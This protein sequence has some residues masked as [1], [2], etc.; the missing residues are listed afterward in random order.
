MTAYHT[1]SPFTCWVK[2]APL[3]TGFRHGGEG[4][5]V[6]EWCGIT[7]VP[8]K[9]QLGNTVGGPY[10]DMVIGFL[11]MCH[12]PS[13]VLPPSHYK[14]SLTP[15][16]KSR[17]V[18]LQH[19]VGE[20]SFG[21][22]YQAIPVGLAYLC[23]CL[24]TQRLP[25][26]I[27]LSASQAL[28]HR[29]QRHLLRLHDIDPKGRYHTRL[30]GLCHLHTQWVG[31]VFPLASTNLDV[32]IRHQTLSPDTI[33]TMLDHVYN[34]LSFIHSNELAHGDVKAD[35]VLVFNHQRALLSD[36]E[37]MVNLRHPQPTTCTYL[38]PNV[39]RHRSLLYQRDTWPFVDRFSWLLMV[40]GLP[41]EPLSCFHSDT[42]QHDAARHTIL[43]LLRDTILSPRYPYPSIRPLCHPIL[44]AA[45]PMP[46]TVTRRLGRD[47]RPIT[48]PNALCPS[49]NPVHHLPITIPETPSL[50]TESVRFFHQVLTWL[51]P[52]FDPNSLDH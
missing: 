26:A 19:V 23:P 33:A 40:S 42:K 45:T 9:S 25:Y 30:L 41:T 27:K 35:N 1:S 32:V 52:F 46:P 8:L 3:R 31:L 38:P 28:L 24:P 2:P 37:G 16:S 29:E 36:W 15:S 21:T 51:P 14:V 20:G 47:P 11:M 6:H 48:L 49:E 5:V 43:S 34:A 39:H 18:R 50:I 13:I 22:V 12:I 4:A 44:Q 17:R 7:V 10:Q